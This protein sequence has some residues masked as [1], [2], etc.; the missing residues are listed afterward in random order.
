MQEKAQVA[1]R[2]EHL[3]SELLQMQAQLDS[4]ETALQEKDIA[5]EQLQEKAQVA[6]RV[7]HLQSELLQMQAQLDSYETALQEK[8]IAIEQLQ[9][10]AQVDERVEHLQSELLQMQAQLDSYE[11][12]LQEKN[13]AIEQLQE[14]AQ[15][16]ERV[17][18]LQ[19]ELLQMQAQLD[20]YETALQE[21][22]IAIEQL[23]EKAQ[24]AERV[25]HLQSELLQTQAQLDSYETAL[26]EK[27]I[28]IE[29]LQ[30]KAQVAERVDHLQ[31]EL[32]QMQ[33][34]LD[35]YTKVIEDKNLQIAQL[36]ETAEKMDLLEKELSE[37]LQEANAHRQLTT[38]REQELIKL[39]EDVLELAQIKEEHAFA[40]DSLKN[41]EEVIQEKN[42]AIEVLEHKAKAGEKLEAL[43]LELIETQE[44]LRFAD[45]S[46]RDLQRQLDS[47]QGKYE[48]ALKLEEL[49][50]TKDRQI[51][52]LEENYR[53]LRE[54]VKEHEGFNHAKLLEK[55]RLIEKH[56]ERA[57]FLEE[58]VA[59]YQQK[60]EYFE[61]NYVARELIEQY[62]F[63]IKG[64]AAQLEELIEKLKKVES[65]KDK[66][67]KDLAD[68]PSHAK[69][70]SRIQGMY[71]QLRTQFEEKSRV[72]NET[73]RELFLALE[74]KGKL[75]LEFQE[76]KKFD[77][78]EEE[79]ALEQYVLKLSE[80]IE[81]QEREIEALHN[82]IAMSG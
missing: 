26:Q 76:L 31:S 52:Q 72:L 54:Q 77:R 30:E 46:Y 53:I 78:A 80:L 35:S 36:A 69:E 45:E 39:N 51:K 44:S 33:A 64:L 47:L 32:L 79:A 13:I 21:K 12:A 5:I 56:A 74:D 71:K 25:E 14:K 60:F 2:V 38:T 34:Q 20:S 8:D 75:E 59:Q 43:Q 68:T 19:S 29:Q 6:E 58:Q 49:T 62:E 37:A 41:Y 23:Q 42:K 82:I 18:H 7:E 55:N 9:E 28:A 17:E 66:I 67:E 40:L 4:Y 73:R 11:T 24:V 15:V 10:K 50:L 22:N 70:L 63:K 57:R 27:N 16:A 1:E 65:E 3:Q 61:A 81:E 48:E